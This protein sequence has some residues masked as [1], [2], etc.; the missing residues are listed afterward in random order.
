EAGQTSLSLE[1]ADRQSRTLEELGILYTTVGNVD[2][3]GRAFAA[4]L[5][6]LEQRSRQETDPSVKRD[7]A[8]SHIKLA[9]TE[10]AQGNL[11][12]SL[13]NYE[14]ARGMLQELTA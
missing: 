10:V 2:A 12:S 6:N 4:L 11:P 5:A 8:I 13:E 3:A 14:A 9:N 1:Q 7:L